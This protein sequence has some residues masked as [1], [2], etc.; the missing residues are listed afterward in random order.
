M[1]DTSF[2]LQ[3]R[4]ENSIKKT[5]TPT[6]EH[7]EQNRISSEKF[8][9]YFDYPNLGESGYVE[10]LS[11]KIVLLFPE[12]KDVAPEAYKYNQSISLHLN[13][14]I[15]FSY[16]WLPIY[17]ISDFFKVKEMI[18]KVYYEIKK[19]T[20]LYDPSQSFNYCTKFHDSVLTT[21]NTDSFFVSC[22]ENNYNTVIEVELKKNLHHK[23]FT[24]NVSLE[25]YIGK[26][27]VFTTDELF[28]VLNEN[29][30]YFLLTFIVFKLLKYS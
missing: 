11:N 23:P 20:D 7:F 17:T 12:K 26:N 24:S 14:H 19:H 10:I 28:S 29:D 9:Y 8:A 13:K 1:S 25:I 22:F 3:D 16:Q 18:S 4:T 6:K 27:K 30:F 15:K 2:F 21:F 5:T